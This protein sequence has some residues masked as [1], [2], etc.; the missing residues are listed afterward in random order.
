MGSSGEPMKRPTRL[1]VDTA[2]STLAAE[3]ACQRSEEVAM[4]DELARL[5]GLVDAVLAHVDSARAL[6]TRARAAGL[7]NV[8]VAE[9]A[10]ALGLP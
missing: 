8:D 2:L 9:L 6:I 10:T 5:N 3:I 7:A 4:A 1:Q